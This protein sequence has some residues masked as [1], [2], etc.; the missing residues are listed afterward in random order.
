MSV[1][2]LYG[3]NFYF[4]VASALILVPT[5]PT[6]KEIN[7]L[8]FRLRLQ[9]ATPRQMQGDG[10]IAHVSV[11]CGGLARQ[12]VKSLLGDRELHENEDSILIPGTW[13]V[14]S[15]LGSYKQTL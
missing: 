3:Q 13:A 4:P 11:G 14:L 9:S 2:P 15:S 5:D 10:R 1:I 6:E 7:F 8:L 12:G